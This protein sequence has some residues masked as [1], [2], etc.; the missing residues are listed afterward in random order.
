MITADQFPRISVE[1]LAEERS[2]LDER[3]GLQGVIET[4]LRK[5]RCRFQRWGFPGRMS[6]AVKPRVGQTLGVAG[7]RCTPRD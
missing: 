3:S 4:V 2:A 1:F 6:D 5:H 7:D